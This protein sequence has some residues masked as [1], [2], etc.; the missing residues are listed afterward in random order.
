MD[1]S[2]LPQWKSHKI[3]RAARIADIV[4]TVGPDATRTLHLDDTTETW[5]SH[6][7]NKVWARFIPVTGDYL[8][9][10]EDGYVSFSPAKAF[11]G[12]Y[13]RVEESEETRG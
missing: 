10:Y 8:V 2:K 7:D 9:V 11:E 12:G 13:A 5:A 6:I 3:V 1:A 4:T